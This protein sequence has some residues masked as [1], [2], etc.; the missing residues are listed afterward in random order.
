MSMLAKSGS[1]AVNQWQG[2]KIIAQELPYFHGKFYEQVGNNDM[3][4]LMSLLR[5]TNR[6]LSF[7]GFGVL[8]LDWNLLLATTMS[9]ATFG[10]LMM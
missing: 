5:V 6:D 2:I 8:K 10:V 7:T 1:R 9:L 4:F 3:L